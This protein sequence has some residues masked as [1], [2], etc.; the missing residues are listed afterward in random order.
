ML[1]LE[2]CSDF[3]S[4]RHSVDKEVERDKMAVRTMSLGGDCNAGE[5]DSEQGGGIK[6]GEDAL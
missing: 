5:S 6:E 1:K 2:N 4:V 3:H